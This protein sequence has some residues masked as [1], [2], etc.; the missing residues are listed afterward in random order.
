M[1]G[2]FRKP[3][4]TLAANPQR[5]VGRAPAA[6]QERLGAELLPEVTHISREGRRASLSGPEPAS[7]QWRTR[8]LFALPPHGVAP[9]AAAGRG[10]ALGDAGAAGH[11]RLRERLLVP[12]SGEV[13]RERERRWV[14][15]RASVK[16][17]LP[18]YERFSVRSWAVL[19]PVSL[20][21]CVFEILS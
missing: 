4:K 19:W 15:V 6:S 11:R 10:R 1:P 17:L 18:V 13:G 9:R 21:M 7:E 5:L 14:F 2:A 3:T 20:S 12:A 8:K 16:Q